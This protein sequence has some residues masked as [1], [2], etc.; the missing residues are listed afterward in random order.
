MLLK[1]A[2]Y[3]S[4]AFLAIAVFDTIVTGKFLALLGPV[5]ILPITLFT[6]L[7]PRLTLWT[8]LLTLLLSISLSGCS[9]WL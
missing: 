5:V 6:V 4:D 7:L 9:T 3:M 1:Y 8:A 2:A